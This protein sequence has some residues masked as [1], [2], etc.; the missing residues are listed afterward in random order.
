MN[1]FYYSEEMNKR[2]ENSLLMANHE[3]I[4]NLRG[5][6]G[7]H[8]SPAV[9]VQLPHLLEQRRH[10]AKLLL[11]MDESTTDKSIMESVKEI[12]DKTNDQ[13]RNELFL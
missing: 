1:K 7:Y 5:S 11:S 9:I 8:D 2:K 4:R 6:A 12:I 3:H 13:I 10:Y